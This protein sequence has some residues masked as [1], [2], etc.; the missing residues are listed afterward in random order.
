[1]FTV[2]EVVSA[3]ID[4]NGLFQSA[5][6]ATPLNPSRIDYVLIYMVDEP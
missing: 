5:L 2:G 3:A 1:M 6:L 4:E